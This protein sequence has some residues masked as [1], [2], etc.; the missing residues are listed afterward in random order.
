MGKGAVMILV[1]SLVLILSIR[2]VLG[3]ETAM[4]HVEEVASDVK[5][6]ANNF[7][8]SAGDAYDDTKSWAEW[9]TDKIKLVFSYL[10]IIFYHKKFN[11]NN[12]NK[13]FF[14]TSVFFLRY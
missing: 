14:Y 1:F 8:E 7:K 4:D 2:S 9:A 6:A 13:E 12:K 5:E 3:D 10:L 11:N